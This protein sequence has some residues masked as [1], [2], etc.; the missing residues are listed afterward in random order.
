M[1]IC[2]F[3]IS[4]HGGEQKGPS[5]ELIRCLIQIES[6]GN[7]RA[8]GDKH[9]KN[10]AYGP[11]QVR[12]LVCDDINKRF[13]TAY[14][15]EQC[16]GNLP[17]SITIFKKYVTMWGTEKRLGREPTDD[18]YARIWNGGPNGWKWNATQKYIAKV[19]K[20]KTSRNKLLIAR[21]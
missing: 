11:L 5:D 20:V 12:Q 17:L 2:W 7:A 6:S 3:A 14:K 16:L 15:A 19:H 18:D 9:L 21:K 10:K 13:G 1:L 4:V 8:V